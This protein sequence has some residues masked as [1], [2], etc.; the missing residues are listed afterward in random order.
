MTDDR[1][2]AA[3]EFLE[4]MA[5]GWEDE[6]PPTW[7]SPKLKDAA[8]ILALLASDPPRAV[9]CEAERVGIH[10]FHDRGQVNIHAPLDPWSTK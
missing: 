10:F 5:N 4:G 6:E 1:I 3:A 8:H 7:W 2:R 9:L